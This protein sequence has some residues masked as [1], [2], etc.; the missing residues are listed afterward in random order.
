MK[1]RRSWGKTTRAFRAPLCSDPL[2]QLTVDVILVFFDSPKTTDFFFPLHLDKNKTGGSCV[3]PRKTYFSPS[4]LYTTL[5]AG[6]HLGKK[7]KFTSSTNNNGFFVAFGA[8]KWPPTPALLLPSSVIVHHF[9]FR[10]SRRKTVGV[11]FGLCR[12]DTVES[13]KEALHLLFRNLGEWTW[14]AL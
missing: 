7:K 11:V 12:R 13:V 1:A 8:G 4:P 6:G 3:P 9:S 2:D 14:L 10:F 5:V